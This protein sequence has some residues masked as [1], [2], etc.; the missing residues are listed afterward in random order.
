MPNFDD[1]FKR[2]TG[3]DPSPYQRRFAEEGET[4]ELVDAPTGLGKAAMAVLNPCG[5]ISKIS[6]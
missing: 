4:A 3:N 6:A 2:A 1:W 5:S